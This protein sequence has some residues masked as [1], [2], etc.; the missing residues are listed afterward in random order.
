MSRQPQVDTQQLGMAWQIPLP[1]QLPLLHRV[2]R[3]VPA[4]LPVRHRQRQ[5]QVPA[6]PVRPVQVPVPVQQQHR[7]D[8]RTKLRNIRRTKG[9]V[10]VNFKR[11]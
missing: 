2:L 1:R 6:H 11:T 10:R 8:K 9:N 4:Q 7:H 3:Q 5:A